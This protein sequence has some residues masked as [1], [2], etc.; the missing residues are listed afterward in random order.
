M[1]DNQPLRL[2]VQRV[3][4]QSFR[5]SNHH[6]C[7]RHLPDALRNPPVHL[8]NATKAPGQVSPSEIRVTLRRPPTQK[9]LAAP[10]LLHIRFE[11]FAPRDGS[12]IPVG[13]PRVLD[14][15]IRAHESAIA[16]VHHPREALRQ[17]IHKLQ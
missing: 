17:Q 8:A 4:R 1:R 9:H 7:Y 6:C 16:H 2:Q 15:D 10:L 12:N 14:H 11:T 13:A 3:G 5:G